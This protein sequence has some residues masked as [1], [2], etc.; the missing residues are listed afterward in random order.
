MQ[1]RNALAYYRPKR[2]RCRRWAAEFRDREPW[3]LCNW[4]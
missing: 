1:R 4:R 2:T 3:R